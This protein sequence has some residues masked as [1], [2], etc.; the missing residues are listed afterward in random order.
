MNEQIIKYFQGE[1]RTTE[2][3]QF[4]REVETN[5]EL[6]EQFIEYKNMRALLALSDQVDNKDANKRG[7]IRFNKLITTRKIRKIILHTASYA[8]VVTLLILSTYW[9]TS[10]HLESQQSVIKVENTLYVPAGQRVRLTLQD[11]TEVWLNSQTKLTYP[12]L[13]SDNE[14]RVTVEGEAFFDVAKNPQKP[15][16]V[17]TQ[18]LEMKVLGTKFNVCSYPGEEMIQTSLLEGKLKVYFPD[19][20][21]NGIILKPEELVTVTGNQMKIASLPHPDYFLWRD[22]VYSFRNEP[23]IDIL[24]KLELYYDIKIIVK[25][26][27]IYK[28][29]YTGKFRQRDGIDNILRM[30]QKIHQFKI[31]KDEENNIITLSR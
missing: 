6:K 31:E 14:R 27:S 13:F 18:G 3:L 22:G 9:F 28:W 19:S 17:S 8:A 4:L 5:S 2:K 29:E 26:Q 30:I 25:D 11:G 23:L 21:S 16:I 24:K 10:N 15:F 1:L 7:Y 12:A 20:E